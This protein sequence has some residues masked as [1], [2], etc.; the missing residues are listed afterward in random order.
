VAARP[1]ASYAGLFGG[2]KARQ[3]KNPA[4]EATA[5]AITWKQLAI[6]PDGVD[7]MRLL[8]SWRWLIQGAM[9]P[10]VLTAM[11]DMFLQDMTGNVYW[12]N[13]IDGK[14]GQVATSQAE[15]KTMM[16]NRENVDEWFLPNMVGE[17]LAAG[18]TLG[19]QECYSFKKAPVLGGSFDVDNIEPCDV[20]VHFLT[21]GQIHQ[22][23]QGAA[24]QEPAAPTAE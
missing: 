6:D 5:M 3:Q 1:P 12:L 22:Q 8:K 9:Q 16:E 4:Q 17:L 18:K 2:Q 10:M 24:G 23:Q 19:P 20:H 7:T 14:L 21:A 13:T 11:G 15:F